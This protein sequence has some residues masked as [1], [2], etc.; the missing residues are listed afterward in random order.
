[1]IGISALKDA[2]HFIAPSSI[3]IHYQW[4]ALRPIGGPQGPLKPDRPKYGGSSG[5][6][7]GNS[8]QALQNK[9]ATIKMVYDQ[10]TC[11]RSY[12][13]NL[14][15]REWVRNEKLHRIYISHKVA[16]CNG[17]AW[18]KQ[19]AAQNLD[20]N[21]PTCYK[22]TGTRPES[23]TRFRKNKLTSLLTCY[24]NSDPNTHVSIAT[25]NANSMI[26]HEWSHLCYLSY[27][28][29]TPYYCSKNVLLISQLPP[30]DPKMYCIW[31]INEKDQRQYI[32]ERLTYQ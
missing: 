31:W 24:H 13:V 19:S 7:N 17:Y 25:K 28:L 8:K 15:L 32:S 29:V 14:K 4:M 26:V 6:V 2:S 20:R 16:K 18:R 12:H 10:Q 27:G 23:T 11:D 1:M 9:E 21:G 3:V 5:V 30:I 22:W